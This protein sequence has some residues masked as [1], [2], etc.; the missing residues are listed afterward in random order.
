MNDA[1]RLNLLR[2]SPPASG[3]ADAGDSLASP[4]DIDS[5]NGYPVLVSDTGGRIVDASETAAVLFGYEL[6]AML[7]LHISDLVARMD[8]SIL[9]LILKSE[10]YGRRVVLDALCFRKEGGTFPAE[11]TLRRIEVAND[12][13][14]RLHFE[15]REVSERRGGG[16]DA[17]SLVEARIARAERLEMAGTLAG[18]IAHDFNNLLTPLLAYPELIKREIK[19]NPTV[20]EYLDIMERTASDM[21]RL[22]HQ[23]L[24]LSRRGHIGNDVFTVNDIAE[25]AAALFQNVMPASIALD[26]DLAENLLAVKG[27]RDQI[28]RVIENLLQNA[29][30]AMGDSGRLTVRTE[31]VYLDAPVG[32]YGAVNVG[33]YVKISVSDTG[34]GIPDEIK[35]KIF[36]PFFTTK[37]GGKKRGSGLGLS[38]VHGIVR[39]HHG[40]VDLETAVGKGST[41][42]VYLPIFRQEIKIPDVDKLPHGT[43]R[44]LVVDDD[45]L[46]LRVLVE[47]LAVLGYTAEGVPSGEEAFRAL[48][49]GKRYELVVLDMV[50]EKGWDGL[51][52]F[53]A[54]RR[55][56]PSQRVVLISGFTKAARNVAKAQELGAGTY[57]RKPL[58]IERVAR[59]VRDELDAGQNAGVE[60]VRSTRRVLIADDEAMIR[61]LFSMIIQSEFPDAVVDQAANGTEA[62]NAFREGRPD[63]IIMDLQMPELDGREAFVEIARLCE[64]ERWRLPSVIFCTGFAPPESLKSILDSG[65]VHCL[66]RKPVKADVL[67]DAI[68]R[69]LKIS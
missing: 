60:P 46:Q 48:R 39:D 34:S 32:Q 7:S 2:S 26:I 11:I 58:T 19:D 59:V 12:G 36:D 18:Q 31:N 53:K 27:N 43:E 54:L 1:I 14:H 4:C 25:Q 3:G 40:Y 23:L 41:F 44:I 67:L 69:R 56:V 51:E 66:L 13:G 33:E 62:V 47:I 63:V 16:D 20:A 9:N 8:D 15:V 28:R 22:T 52:T 29:L 49:E 6:T 55:I 68:R 57:L 24:S 17:A 21:S 45:A 65:D 30:D 10:P 64:K 42:Y 35:E 38:I 61:K 50:L 5:G 37:R